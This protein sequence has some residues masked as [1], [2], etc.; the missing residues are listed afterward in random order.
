MLKKLLVLASIL[1]LTS[2][3][4]IFKKDSV[5][6]TENDNFAVEDVAKDETYQ[7]VENEQQA[8]ELNKQAADAQEEVEVQDR[9]FFAYDS[10]EL[11]DDAK[12]ILDVQTEW[13]KSDPSIKVTVEGHCDE[14]GTREYNIAL[15][16]RRAN[17]AKSYLVKNGVGTARITTISYG[18]EHPVFFGTDEAVISK[19]RR[20]VTVTK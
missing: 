16:D 14:R 17:A 2:C 4:S 12:K 8:A 20:A 10:S 19:N 18:K 3:G 15:G 6:T 13:L 11:S 5:A 1:A 9:V 7:P